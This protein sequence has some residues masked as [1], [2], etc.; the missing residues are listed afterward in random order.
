MWNGFR[1]MFGAATVL[2]SL[3]FLGSLIPRSPHGPAEPRSRVRINRNHHPHVGAKQKA[4][5]L[6]RGSAGFVT[7]KVTPR[8]EGDFTS[9]AFAA[10]TRVS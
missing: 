4:K 7:V 2:A 10:Q 8:R 6:A 1:S 3:S 5:E 9:R